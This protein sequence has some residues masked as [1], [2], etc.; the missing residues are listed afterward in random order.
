MNAYIRLC[1]STIPAIILAVDEPRAELLSI[2][3][4]LMR[5]ELT[6][7]ER[8]EL[9]Q[10]RREICQTI[11]LAGDSASTKESSPRTI[12]QLIRRLAGRIGMK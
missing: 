11:R 7:A 12:W 10:R 6:P 9:R 2:D 8:D 4:N 1:R 3:G 5:Q